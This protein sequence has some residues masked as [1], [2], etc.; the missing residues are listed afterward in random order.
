MHFS[1]M[2]SINN[3]YEAYVKSL[4]QEVYG[5]IIW[6]QAKYNNKFLIIFLVCNQIKF[7]N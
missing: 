7:Q 1:I 4:L 2:N 6:Y 5:M 3:K